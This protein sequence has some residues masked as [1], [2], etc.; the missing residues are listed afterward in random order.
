MAKR[1]PKSSHDPG[2]AV[3]VIGAGLSGL[4]TAI[5]LQAAGLPTTLIEARASV[6]GLLRRIEAQG[7]TFEE[8]PSLL[9]DPA[10]LREL[11]SI[12]G[13]DADADPALRLLPVD[14]ACRYL[15]SDGTAFDAAADP[16][17]L[18]RQVGRIASADIPGIEAW[19]DWSALVRRETWPDLAEAAPQGWAG[20]L[21][22][23]PVLR[24][25]RGWQS[26]AGLIAGLI[27]EPHLRQALSHPALLAG[28][29]P[30]SA[31][32]LVLAGQH[33]AGLGP[34][35]WPAGGMVRLAET[36]RAR[37]ERLGGTVRLHDPVVQIHTLGNRANE[38]ET[39]SGWRAHFAAV[40]STGDAAATYR[41][42]LRG[43]PR[44]PAM[45]ARLAK[46]RYA[47][48]A[49]TVHFALAGSWPG[50]GH[51][52]VLL[53]PRFD[54]LLADVFDLGVLPRDMLIWL[55][56]PT[57]TE[58]GLAPPGHSLMCATIPVAHLGKLPIDWETVGPVIAQRVLDEVGRRLIPD[59]SDRILARHVTTPRDLALDLGLH[60]GSCWSLE[61][62]AL[63]SGPLRLPHRDARI[64]NLFFAGAATHPGAGVAGVLAGAKACA[65]LVTQEV[66]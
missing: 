66:I 49:L 13:E 57:V 41:Q 4:A 58:P 60:L 55:H 6:G 36:L 46:R 10:C 29:N 7:F 64:A 27:K 53:G 45:G 8:G 61:Q 25:A 18:I 33:L 63:Q 14:P 47:P 3:C 19:R 30:A 1:A 21:R 9:A 32:A 5:R 17:E 16:A 59:I 24:R 62:T 40:A 28:A 34:A 26:A 50:I 11:W 23:V 37:F 38:V 48:S 52:T 43:N 15:W 35:Y 44:G 51:H 65:K 39:Q 31:S 20:W 42:L 2:R 54:D 22:T 56:H 12:T